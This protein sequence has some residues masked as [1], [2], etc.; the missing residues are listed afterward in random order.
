[1]KNLISI[2]INCYNGEKYLKR[3]IQS[4]LNQNYQNW[5]VIFWD[6]Q[7]S[8]NSKKIFYS[9]KDDR[10]KYFYAKEHTTLYKARNHA[11]DKTSGE[12]I[13]FLDCDDNW[14]N[15]FLSS[16]VEFF[17]N[18]NFDYSYSNSHYYLEKSQRKLLHTKKELKSGYIYNFLAVNYV[19]TISSLVIKK[20]I[21]KEVSLFNPKYNII[22]D[23]DLVMKISK[24]KNAYAIQ[25]PLLEIRIHGN[26][27][28]DKNRKMFF[29][30]FYDW[31]FKQKKDEYFKCNQKYFLK[32][33]LYLLL[34]S[35]TPSF[36]KNFLKKK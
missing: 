30:E 18:K 19:V 21:F 12:Y 14:Y 28:L 23:F 32:K 11:I 3:A 31:Y 34:V 26:N 7:S 8:D 2:I 29:K 27:F 10:L 6:N 24:N 9:F 16:R 15:N 25:E 1:M 13:A 4:V 36:I 33:L 20:K 22:G 17:Q 35:L 5:E